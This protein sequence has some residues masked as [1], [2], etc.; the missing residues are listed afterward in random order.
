MTKEIKNL[1]EGLHN[2]V[3]NIMQKVKKNKTTTTKNRGRKQEKKDK[4]L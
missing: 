1:I 2:K 3:E 4:K